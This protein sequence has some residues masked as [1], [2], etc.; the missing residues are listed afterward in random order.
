[1]KYVC[2]QKRGAVVYYFYNTCTLC[3]CSSLFYGI[4]TV[5]G[6]YT[7][8]QQL[9]R[10]RTIK[11]LLLIRKVVQEHSRPDLEYWCSGVMVCFIV[12][13][14]CVRQ[15]STRAGRVKVKG[16]CRLR[17]PR[18]IKKRKDS[19]GAFSCCFLFFVGCSGRRQAKATKTWNERIKFVSSVQQVA[20]LPIVDGCLQ[21]AQCARMRYAVQYCALKCV[22]CWLYWMYRYYCCC[23]NQFPRVFH[24]LGRESRDRCCTRPRRL[25]LHSPVG[26]CLL[27]VGMFCAV[28][29]TYASRNQAQVPFNSVFYILRRRVQCWLCFSVR[30]TKNVFQLR[31]NVIIVLLLGR[32]FF[33]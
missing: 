6:W 28:V 25:Q 10:Y 11:L 7:G 4:S 1:M 22:D 23:S 26:L 8:Q 2:C 24:S 33:L 31:R 16:A 14:F 21:V 12:C 29:R 27:G 17:K 32:F 13:V 18:P 5:V 15:F 9:V 30:L 3:A 20:Q 19:W